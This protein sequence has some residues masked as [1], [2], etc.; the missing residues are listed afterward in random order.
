MPFFR[1]LFNVI[2]IMIVVRLLTFLFT[3]ITQM[4]QSK[5]AKK[6]YE[7]MEEEKKNNPQPEKKEEQP[8]EIVAEQESNIEVK[9]FGK[10]KRNKEVKNDVS[11]I[12]FDS[13]EET[14]TQTQNTQQTNPNQPIVEE[15]K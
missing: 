9:H 10:S 15:W 6:R 7:K 5:K 3:R 4:I 1:F 14:K 11:D 2:I 12:T 8:T 13:P